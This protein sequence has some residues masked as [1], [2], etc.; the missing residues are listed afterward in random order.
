MNV[1]R[2][3]RTA[4]FVY[5]GEPSCVVSCEML[6]AYRF[7]RVGSEALKVVP[8]SDW[9]SR[10]NAIETVGR[11]D[12]VAIVIGWPLMPAS[13]VLQLFATPAIDAYAA[14]CPSSR[15]SRA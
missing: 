4:D 11:A 1:V 7:R 10:M 2:V 14:S 3:E 8:H 6:P 5:A 13:A 9:V 12:S 15:A